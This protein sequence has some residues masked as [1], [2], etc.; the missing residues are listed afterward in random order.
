MGMNAYF[1]S[2]RGGGELDVHDSIITSLIEV[3][4]QK[5]FLTQA[6]WDKAIKKRVIVE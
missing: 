4:E 5:G 3:L 1:F 2:A 6:E